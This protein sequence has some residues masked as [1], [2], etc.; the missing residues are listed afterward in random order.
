MNS[1]KLIVTA[2]LLLSTILSYGQRKKREAKE[3]FYAFDENWKNASMANSKYFVRRTKISDTCWQWDTYNMYGPM[4]KSE[5]SLDENGS[6]VHGRVVVFNTSGKADSICS[7]YMGSPNGKWYIYNDPF[8]NIVLTYDMG[9][10]VDTKKTVKVKGSKP[11]D[12]V[13]QGEQEST[14]RGGVSGWQHY[15]NRNLRYP[16]RAFN[17]RIDG[18]A[19]VSFTIDSTGNV[20]DCYIYRSV[21]FSLDEES[22]RIIRESPRWNPSQKDGVPVTSYKRQPIIFKLGGNFH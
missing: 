4:M 17:A 9:K 3:A 11:K 18:S 8:Y 10:L 7:Y 15:L 1:L 14:F 19:T 16:Q 12:S 6:T 20:S 5:Q 2:L 21:E 22:L 13:V